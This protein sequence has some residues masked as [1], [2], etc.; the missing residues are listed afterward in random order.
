MQ[1]SGQNTQNSM[2]PFASVPAGTRIYAIGDSHGCVAKLI[3]LHK[4]IL[5][6]CSAAEPGAPIK[7]RVAVYLGDYVDRGPDTRALLDLLIEVPLAGFESIHL[8]GNHEAMIRDVLDGTGDPLLW[9]GNGGTATL[10]SYGVD[11]AVLREPASRGSL[12]DALAAQVP[13]AHRCFLAGLR[14]SHIE[15][16]Y[17]FVHAG[18]NPSRPLDAQ[19]AKDLL[20]IREPFLNAT[21]DLGKMIVHGHTPAPAPQ[22][23]A[24]RIGIDTGACYGGPLTALVLEGDSRRFLQI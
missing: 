12:S 5:E 16:D 11:M 13:A 4:A 24:N 17:M 7:R 3:A 10:R 8:Q 9:L 20:W 19:E 2:P 6:D 1:S 23:R 22:V 18:V 21:G 14:L 15:G